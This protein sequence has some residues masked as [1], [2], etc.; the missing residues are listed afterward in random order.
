M[1]TTLIEGILKL[2][3]IGA[4]IAFWHEDHGDKLMVK[5]K[6]S[7]R[8]PVLDYWVAEIERDPQAFEE[9]L[10]QEIERFVAEW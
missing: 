6:D 8:A 10:C 4:A 1:A 5:F 7:T 9:V 3:K 2:E